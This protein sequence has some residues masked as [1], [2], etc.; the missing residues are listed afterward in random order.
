MVIEATC[1]SPWK[2]KLELATKPPAAVAM[3]PTSSK[4]APTELQRR[5]L[6]DLAV[7]GGGERVGVGDR[8]LG[9]RRGAGSGVVGGTDGGSAN[10]AA[11]LAGSGRSDED[12]GRGGVT[13]AD[14]LTEDAEGDQGYRGESGDA[15]EL[16]RLHCCLRF[17]WRNCLRR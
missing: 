11:P 2:E 15:N 10:Y 4:P 16:L 8:R 14:R 7:G 9:R 1:C 17:D 13:V 3:R 5:R 6:D 12:G